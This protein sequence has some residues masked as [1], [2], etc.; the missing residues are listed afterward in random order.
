MGTAVALRWV[1]RSW[2]GRFRTFDQGIKPGVSL[3]T[4]A[5]CEG[6]LSF[7]INMVILWSLTT[8]WGLAW[9]TQLCS[10]SLCSLGRRACGR[11]KF[12]RAVGT[13]AV[14]CPAA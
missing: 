2:Q 4:G 1:P 8:R 14:T 11:S 10:C 7:A 6:V 13:C 9:R 12:R 3:A 5:A